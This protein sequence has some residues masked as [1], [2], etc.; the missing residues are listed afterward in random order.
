MDQLD[1]DTET[2]N[3]AIYWRGLFI[4][5]YSGI[6]FAL[7][8]LLVRA[9]HHPAYN[10]F[11]DLPRHHEGKLK[12]LEQFIDAE[13]P[14][15]RYAQ[16]LR[17]MLAEFTALESTRHFLA[18]GI[19]VISRNAK[20]RKRLCLSMYRHMAGE[21]HQGLFQLTVDE[22]IRVTSD[23]APTSHGFTALVA[24]IVKEAP[25]PQLVGT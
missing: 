14:I 5:R 22:L 8:D 23:L 2:M 7:T 25:L 18:H 21:V 16:P 13:G 24:R 9:R 17:E 10:A 1:A 20:D 11:G 12:R 4:Q 6:E 15:A 3:V 19:M